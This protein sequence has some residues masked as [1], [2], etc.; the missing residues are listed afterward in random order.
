MPLLETFANASARGFEI[1]G[2]PAGTTSDYE[3]IS[4]A[5]GTGSSGTIT[6]SSIPST[7]KHLQIRFTAKASAGS[8]MSLQFNNVTSAVYALHRLNGTGSAVSSG[9][10]TSQNYVNLPSAIDS[11]TANSYAAG[12]MDILDYSSTT[13]NKTLRA[14]YGF[15]TGSIY[16]ASG[17]YN[18]T[19]AVSTITLNNLSGNYTTQSRFSLYGIKG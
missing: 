1:F 13:K 4:T 6:F 9:A 2:P 15:P 16:L 19:S 8:T 14:L 12:V 18:D 17:L 5:Y 11:A 10:S 3:L 7:Y